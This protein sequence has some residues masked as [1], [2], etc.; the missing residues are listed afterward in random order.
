[1]TH[2][3]RLRVLQWLTVLVPALCAGLYETVRHSLLAAELPLGL[4]TLLAAALVL[5]ISFGF[6]RVSFGL[7]RKMEA[8]LVERNRQLEAL[9]REVQRLAVIEE[10][11]RL[12]REM[13]D[14]VAQVLAYLLVRLDTIEGLL[15]R[16]R[17][18]DAVAEVRRLRGSSEAAYAEVREAITGLRT[19]PEAGAAGLA[20]ALRHYVAEF[21][22][23]CAL[24]A[25]FVADGLEG[26]DGAAADLRP[27]AELQLLRIVQEALANVRKHAQA[28]R[29]IV[30]FWRSAAGWH[31]QVEDDG[32]G[33]DTAAPP[34]PGRQHFGLPIM[35]ERAESLGGALEVISRPGEGTTVR[36]HVPHAGHDRPAVAAPTEGAAAT[37]AVGANGAKGARLNGRAAEPAGR[38][39]AGGGAPARSPG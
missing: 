15:E 8:R 22:D 37:P 39:R 29:V 7:I 33:F 28:S 11:D 31:L 3:S 10:R 24:T 16:H 34:P 20:A 27:E 13:H 17:T 4:G 18:D 30:R 14:G 21:G 23:R 6:A 1:V 19:R 38:K 26:I 35:R 12:A 32:Q 36:A 5:A 25:T 2:P 9:S